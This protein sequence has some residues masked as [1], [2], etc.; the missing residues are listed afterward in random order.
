MRAG[1]RI[2]LA[3]VVRRFSGDPCSEPVTA[4]GGVTMSIEPGEAVAIVGESGSGKSSLLNAIGAMDLPT[5]G[6]VMVDGTDITQLA[7]H[8]RAAFRRR[9]GFVFQQFHLLAS[10]GALENVA[11]PLVPY[12]RARVA[13][14]RAAE[15]L[16]E[17][18]LAARSRA[19][20][21]QLS[22][23]QQ[24]RVA[25]AR[26]LVVDPVLLLADEPTGNL[27][28]FTGRAILDLLFDVRERRATTLVLVTHDPAVAA[29][30]DRVIRLHEGR[31]V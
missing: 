27:D 8:E 29:S 15:C 19:L 26:A 24:Q 31:V 7:T 18:G 11:A 14:K 21:G 17:V 28:V 30:C 3:D 13:R 5:S 10:L 9:L 1:A 16:S 12:T 4:L 20:P 23:G 25:I 6:T 2:E 22:G